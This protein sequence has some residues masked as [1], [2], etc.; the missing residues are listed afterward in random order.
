LTALKKSVLATHGRARAYKTKTGYHVARGICWF[1][2]VTT[3]NHGHSTV[4]WLSIDSA[5]IKYLFSLQKYQNLILKYAD[6]QMD[7][8]D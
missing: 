5:I 8:R 2:M 1:Y 7:S 4:H 3:C 6:K